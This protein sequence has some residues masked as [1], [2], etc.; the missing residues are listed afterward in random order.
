MSRETLAAVIVAAHLR[1]KLAVVHV[2]AYQA[3]C[4]AIEAGADV[5][6]HLFFDPMPDGADIGRL[7]A[8]HHA[9]VISTLTVLE[10][11]AGGSSGDAVLNDA[12]IAPYLSREDIRQL[13]RKYPPHGTNAHPRYAEAALRQLK[14][15]SVPILAGTDAS[16]PGT[17][18]GASLHRELELLVKAGLTP[19]EALTAATS[20]PAGVF[21][22][23]DRGR[24]A[25][26]LRADLV[27]VEDDPSRDILATRRIRG[28]W[29][30]GVEVDRRT[31]RAR[32]E[33]ERGEEER[34]Y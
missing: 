14:A 32:L 31:Y 33:Q 1:G 24:I 7:A 34:L 25:P 28:V 3:A 20:R 17:M 21:G 19:V 16:M 10:N 27:L 6:A 18:H 30:R 23:A 8:D 29:K 12:W 2:L 5:L 15:A 11:V 22:L 9:G 13:Q 26:G 4:D